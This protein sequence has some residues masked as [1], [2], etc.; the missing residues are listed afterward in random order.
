M[1]NNTLTNQDGRTAKILKSEDLG[2]GKYL[3]HLAT[4]NLDA[5]DVGTEFT[6]DVGNGTVE[7]VGI[8]DVASIYEARTEQQVLDEDEPG[9]WIFGWKFN[10]LGW[11]VP[12]E[13]GTSLY[14]SLVALNQ[15]RSNLGIQGPTSIS[16]TSGRALA[17]NQKAPIAGKPVQV[18]GWKTTDTRTSYSIYPEYIAQEDDDALYADAFLSW[19]GDSTTIS[20]PG[21]S[22]ATIP[23]Y[24]ATN[25]VPVEVDP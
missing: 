11:I 8:S 19:E 1:L 21:L 4:S 17:V 15:N 12:F 18:N 24:P 14:G 13:E 10:E 20:Q 3:L 9:E 25:T 22:S 2:D 5:W 6:S 23:E 16:G 7:S